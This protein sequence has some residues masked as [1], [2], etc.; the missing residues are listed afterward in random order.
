[1]RDVYATDRLFDVIA[2]SVSEI[3]AGTRDEVSSID[4]ALAELRRR[5]DTLVHRD[6][7][8]TLLRH[9]DPFGTDVALEGAL[10]R[11]ERALSGRP[12]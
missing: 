7:L 6:D 11:V 4:R 5:G 10:A 3:A 9:L 12:V 8:R 1:M 2:E